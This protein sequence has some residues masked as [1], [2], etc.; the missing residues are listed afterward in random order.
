MTVSAIERRAMELG[1]DIIQQPDGTW[2]WK[3][4]TASCGGFRTSEIAA[5]DYLKHG[6]NADS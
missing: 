2:T 3:A 4:Y 5:K 6:T 1:A